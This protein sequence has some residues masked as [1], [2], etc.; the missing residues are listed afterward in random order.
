MREAT[1]SADQQHRVRWESTAQLPWDR[2][3]DSEHVRPLSADSA[4]EGCSP[5]TRAFTQPS[6]TLAPPE[7]L[8]AIFDDI[9][10]AVGGA[11][12]GAAK[13]L[14]SPRSRRQ[15]EPPGTG[16]ERDGAFYLGERAG[17]LRA[18][19]VAGRAAAGLRHAASCLSMI[20]VVKVAIP[21]GSGQQ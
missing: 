4:Q 15:G 2:R 6:T 17:D 20:V 8:T 10:D 16:M 18:A 5:N 12:A 21:L 1:A 13:K 14:R 19:I 11:L 9:V 3:N 7:D